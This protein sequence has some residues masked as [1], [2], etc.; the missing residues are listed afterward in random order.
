MN[1]FYQ[2]SLPRYTSQFIDQPLPAEMMFK[3]GEAKHQQQMQ[4]AQDVAEVSSMTTINPPGYRTEELASGVN[5]KYEQKVDDFVSKYGDKYDSPQAMMELYKLHSD[6]TR[7]PQVQLIKRDREEGDKQWNA[8]VAKT[9]TYNTDIKPGIDP[10]TGMLYQFGPNDTYRPHSPFVETQ[11]THK[12]WSEEFNA[13]KPTISEQPEISYVTDP[14]GV[15]RQQITDMRVETRDK[16]TVLSKALEIAQRIVNP[17]DQFSMYHN[18]DLART[19][20]HEPSLEEAYNSILP[21]A[22]ESMIYK[23]TGGTRSTPEPESFQGSGVNVKG[24]GSEWNTPMTKRFPGMNDVADKVINKGAIDVLFNKYPDE[25]TAVGSN[26]M[27]KAMYGQMVQRHPDTASLNGRPLRQALKSFGDEVENS[28]PIYRTIDIPLKQGKEEGKQLF[29]RQWDD[30]TGKM[31]GN[32]QDTK[33]LGTE[34]IDLENGKIMQNENDKKALVKDKN[35][36]NIVGTVDPRDWALQPVPGMSKIIEVN[37]KKYGIVNPKDAEEQRMVYCMDGDRREMKT[38]VSAVYGMDITRDG[39][40]FTDY[41]QA[42]PSM[43]DHRVQVKT[44]NGFYGVT[45]TEPDGTR[46]VKVFMKNPKNPDGTRDEKNPLDDAGIVNSDNNPNFLKEYNV[47]Q[48]DVS[49]I[50]DPRTGNVMKIDNPMQ[51]VMV[52]IIKDVYENKELLKIREERAQGLK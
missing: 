46:K 41:S 1:R 31:K 22:A 52:Q 36:I 45:V 35:D 47:N 48:F 37:N 7:D 33:L 19:L 27:L 13:I 39:P 34:V 44:A 10:R 4:F 17:T 51:A 28:Q 15:K 32:G 25:K 16:K 40:V 14:N 24:E 38:G 49:S 50:N 23:Q 29:G 43:D 11:D 20:G 6:W 9:K 18:A 3:A 42:G 21:I 8:M 12:H 30:S 26:E 2:P 5:K